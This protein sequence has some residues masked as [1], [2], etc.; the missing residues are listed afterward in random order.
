MAKKWKHSKKYIYNY[1]SCAS[2]GFDVFQASNIYVIPQLK[3]MHKYNSTLH[4]YARN[5][6][7]TLKCKNIQQL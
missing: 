2:L 6:T 4:K 3:Y 7:Y 1:K 5:H